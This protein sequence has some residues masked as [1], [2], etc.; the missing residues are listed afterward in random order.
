[1]FVLVGQI[2]NA[3][4]RFGPMMW[5]PIAN[6]LVSIAVISTYMVLYHDQPAVGGYSARQ[7]A[8]L[9]V[10]STLGI[11]VQAM[12]LLPYLKA[13]GFTIR[14]RLDFFR[15]GLR[16]TVRLGAWTIGFVVVNQIAFFVTTQRATSATSAGG[17]AGYTVFTNAFLLTQVPHS[18][19]TVSLATATVPVMARLAADGRQRHLAAELSSTLRLVLAVMAPCAVVL[20]VLGPVLASALFSWSKSTGDT[21]SL[22]VTLVAFAP[23]LVLFSLHYVVLRGFY[24][25]EDTRTPFFVQCAIAAVNIVL[26]I[27]L[28]LVVSAGLVAPMLAVAYGA[29]YAVGLTVS[30][31]V[32]SGRLGGLEG[33]AL[34]KLTVRVVI[35]AALA[36]G[37][38]WVVVAVM[39]TAGL[40]VGSKAGS[41][42]MLIVGGA[43]SIGVYTLA[44][45]VMRIE[46]VNNI[47]ALV[48]ARA[49]RR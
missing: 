36:A 21:S 10:G 46:E 34:L 30:L 38:A 13:S 48:S 23:G 29:A 40:T 7:E 47:V 24:A 43:A 25:I 6:N 33:K 41:V 20:L 37:G 35:A 4:D 12:L 31:A 39:R 14:P 2:L 45:R 17:G 5:A 19:V 28:T 8:L 9:G 18:V 22:G 32:L 15:T 26:S 42:A 44:A 27:T 11:A 1:M 3:R 49:K 16:H